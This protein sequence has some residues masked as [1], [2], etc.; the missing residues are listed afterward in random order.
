M[1]VLDRTLIL[2]LEDMTSFQLMQEDLLSDDAEFNKWA[3]IAN[4]IYLEVVE[5]A[6]FEYRPYQPEFAANCCVRRNHIL[7]HQM[8]AGKTITTALAIASL[9][10]MS[11]HRPGRVHIVVP[12]ALIAQ[13]WIEDL[14]RVPQLAES[15]QYISDVRELI[16]TEKPILIYRFDFLRNKMSIPRTG[17]RRGYGSTLS[18]REEGTIRSTNGGRKN[19]ADFLLQY[20]R[21]NMLVIDEAHNI[22]EEAK[23]SKLLLKL[24]RKTKRC[25]ALTGTLTD[26]SL[27]SVYTL[28]KFVYGSYFPYRDYAQMKAEFAGGIRLSTNYKSGSVN[29]GSE[30]WIEGLDPSKL[31]TFY[32][33][34][35]RF[36]H[37]VRLSDPEISRYISLPDESYVFHRILPTDEMIQAYRQVIEGHRG[38]MELISAS[39]GVRARA[40]ALRLLNPLIDL[41]NTFMGDT[42]VPKV[43]KLIEIINESEGKVVIYC[44]RVNASEYVYH[45]LANAGINVVRLHSDLTEDERI[46]LLC[47]YNQDPSVKAGVFQIRLG[48]TG[49]DLP[50]TSKLVYYDLPWSLLLIQQAAGR[51][52]RPG[53]RHEKVQIIF[54]SHRG[55]VDE[56]KLGIAETRTKSARLIN[57]FSVLEVGSAEEE[58][59]DFNA[60]SLLNTV[61]REV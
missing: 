3:A 23:R 55:F 48:A 41:S 44:E 43:I 58:T 39:T 22:S 7:N 26:G 57:D 5:G 42:A 28:C 29:N 8:G 18:R 13:R 12:D 27:K 53:N 2:K 31:P 30:R 51:I 34:I 40:A 56:H 36:V 14:G 10:D 25:I 6:G 17:T 61:L 45:Q 11:V 4:D 15:F 60:L 54:L 46:D 33:M 32:K 59:I 49:I 35:G 37:R 20:L 1:S 52:V 24:R 9:Y 47:R 38:Q 19:V 16:H 21:P 50:H